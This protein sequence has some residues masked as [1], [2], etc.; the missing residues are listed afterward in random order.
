MRV[1]LLV[2]TDLTWAV[3]LAR[4]WKGQGDEVTLV[5][6]DGAAAAARQG[7]LRAPVVGDA[8][9]LGIAVLAHDDALRRR[10]IRANRTLEGVKAVDLDEI[11]DLVADGAEKVVWL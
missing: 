7:H 1:A 5:L 11:A 8:L 9:G 10:A 3:E 2:S 6:L 4:T